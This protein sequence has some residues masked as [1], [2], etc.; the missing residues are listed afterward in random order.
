MALFNLYHIIRFSFSNST[1]TITALIYLVGLIIILLA[2]IISI[3][4]YDWTQTIEINL[5]L[6]A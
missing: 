6:N 3:L 5:S 4:Q 2:S 1:S